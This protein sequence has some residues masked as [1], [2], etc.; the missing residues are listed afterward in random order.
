MKF[1]RRSIGKT[2]RDKIRNTRIREEVKTESLE[3]KINKNQ[4]RWFGHVN[5]MNESRIPKQ[6]LECKQQRK[7]PRGRPNTTWLESINEIIK[8][9]K[10]KPVEAK[11]KSLD[12]DLWRK[13]VNAN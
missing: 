1:L 6:M 12:R 2:K 10:W 4:L 9:K 11:R 5:R 8:K 13:F 7:L 3:S